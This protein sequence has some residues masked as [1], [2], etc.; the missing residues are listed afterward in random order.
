VWYDPTSPTQEHDRKNW[1]YPR[2]QDQPYLGEY[3]SKDS[4]VIKQ[5]FAWC[6]DLGID[7]LVISWWG[8]GSFSDEATHAVFQSAVENCT[9]V[10]LCIMIEP[11]Q[12]KSPINYNETYDYVYGEYAEPYRSIYYRLEDKPLVLFWNED[13]FTGSLPR[14]DRFDVKISGHKAYVDWVYHDMIAEFRQFYS[15]LPRE[16]V[17]PVCP[18][19]DD[20][21]VRSP[22]HTVD[23]DYSQGYYINQWSEALKHAPNELDTITICSW[24]EFE[25][26]TA[27]EPHYDRDA[28]SRDPFYLYNVTKEFIRRLKA[29][30]EIDGNVEFEDNRRALLEYCNSQ[31]IAHAGYMFTLILALVALVPQVVSLWGKHFQTRRRRFV[32]FFFAI[33]PLGILG[34]YLVTRTLYWTNLGSAAIQIRF[35]DLPYEGNS[36]AS[37]IDKLLNATV[38]RVGGLNF[39]NIPLYLLL[40]T[41]VVLDFVLSLVLCNARALQLRLARALKTVSQSVTKHSRKPRKSEVQ[42]QQ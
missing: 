13:N 33:I 8:I 11:F 38:N 7:F 15:P 29:T 9:N 32:L 18:R 36:S 37:Q 10:R 12:G 20:Y 30:Q 31:T 26:R 4:D 25:E 39:R 42:E 28:F 21:Y 16:K 6:E 27:I 1:S 24:N 34:S 2:I 17:Y 23:R 40:V 22:N 3:S 35:E 41:L 19:F 14:D 5:H